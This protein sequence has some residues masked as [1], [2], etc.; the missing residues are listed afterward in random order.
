MISLD[1]YDEF[2]ELMD[3]LLLDYKITRDEDMPDVWWVSI[4]KQVVC[5]LTNRLLAG[6]I[7]LL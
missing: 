3:I 5:M 6:H 7:D 1:S 4:D 2:I